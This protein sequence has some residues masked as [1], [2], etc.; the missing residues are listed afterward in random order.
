MHGL[1]SV[2]FFKFPVLNKVGLTWEPLFSHLFS[3]IMWT[4][5]TPIWCSIFYQPTKNKICLVSKSEIGIV[6]IEYTFVEM[7]R[8][9]G[10]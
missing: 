3:F 5:F 2:H 7:S 9:L 4:C 6:D 1:S 10:N 8:D